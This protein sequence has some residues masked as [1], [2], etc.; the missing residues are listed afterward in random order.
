VNLA[1]T[2]SSLYPLNLS[3]AGR[4]LLELNTIKL[5][6]LQLAWK[7]HINY[8][9]SKLS[10]VYFIIRRLVHI[11]N[12]ETF[13]GCIFCLFSFSDEIWNDVLGQ[14]NHIT[15][16]VHSSK[17]DIKNYVGNRPKMF[18]HRLVCETKYFG[19]TMLVIFFFFL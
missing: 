16:G 14:F 4:I 5:F 13:K 8:V 11:L 2:K 19:R 10:V 1:P 3:C 15:L 18:L 6:G 7:M 17:K 12:I 9:L